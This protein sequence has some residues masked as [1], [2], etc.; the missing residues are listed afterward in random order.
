M[1]SKPKE[2]GLV[3]ECSNNNDELVNAEKQIQQNLE[4]QLR[5]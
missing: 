4:P 5:S 3:L 2:E 1:G